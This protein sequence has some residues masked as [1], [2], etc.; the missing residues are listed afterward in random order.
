MSRKASPRQLRALELFA[1]VDETA[2][3]PGV[4]PSATGRRNGPW[5]RTYAVLMREGW[6]EPRRK[7]M[8]G[9][10]YRSYFV[11]T[12]AGRHALSSGSPK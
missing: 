7:R 5:T 11:L 9:G 6:I 4:A 12:E 3:W 10:I 1:T 2:L 8:G